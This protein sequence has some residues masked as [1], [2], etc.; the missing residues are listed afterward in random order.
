MRSGRLRRTVCRAI[1]GPVV[2]VLLAGS[3]AAN[4]ADTKVEISAAKRRLAELETRIS[5][6][7]ARVLAVRDSMN[8]L[9]AR[10]GATRRLYEAIQVRLKATRVQRAH[11]EARYLEIRT[12]IGNAAADA[13]MRGPGYRFDAL[14]ELE[15]LSDATYVLGYTNA[16]TH[17]HAELAAEAQMLA[18]RLKKEL[19]IW[20]VTA[21]RDAKPQSVPAMTCSRPTTEA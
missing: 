14:M 5:S 19:V 1:A 7:Q 2:L 10:V 3:A 8:A 6:E 20:M 17:H 16:I 18:A 13:Y 11:V 9:A 4:P 21:S 15:S 12:A